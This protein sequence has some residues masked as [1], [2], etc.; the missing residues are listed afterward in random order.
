[1]SL[2]LKTNSESYGC[3]N[4]PEL[5]D[6]YASCILSFHQPTRSHI[7]PI[8]IAGESFFLVHA[9]LREVWKCLSLF[10]WQFLCVCGR[11]RFF[12]STLG[13]H[14]NR[15]RVKPDCFLP[16]SGLCAFFFA[17]RYFKLFVFLFV[18]IV[19]SRIIEGFVSNSG[20]LIMSSYGWRIKILIWH[21]GL[22]W[23]FYCCW[24][25]FLTQQLKRVMFS[26]LTPESLLAMSQSLVL[27]VVL[28]LAELYSRIT[29][30]H[31]N[32]NHENQPLKSKRVSKCVSYPAAKM[33]P[34]ADLF[35][36]VQWCW[37]STLRRSQVRARLTWATNTRL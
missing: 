15:W 28:E 14:L 37:R 18:C 27:S 9:V 3:P 24:F 23:S 16:N 30:G 29:K 36:M 26:S 7:K 32:T 19:F 34:L 22:V 4:V 1:M 11:S 2:G 12:R 33:P 8:Y 20:P 10:S 25:F 17:A 35:P 5:W 31:R 21:F 13:M 6:I